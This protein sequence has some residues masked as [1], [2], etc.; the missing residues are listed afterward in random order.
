MCLKEV[1]RAEISSPLFFGLDLYFDC[2]QKKKKKQHPP[3]LFSQTECRPGKR[4]RF[5]EA[6]LVDHARLGRVCFAQEEV[7]VFFCFF[8]SKEKRV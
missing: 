1:K 3:P 8:Y 6:D 5:R 7:A 4:S 2:R